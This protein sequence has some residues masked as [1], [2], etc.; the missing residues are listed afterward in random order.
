SH[1]ITRMTSHKLNDIIHCTPRPKGQASRDR[2]SKQGG[3]QTTLTALQ[4]EPVEQRILHHRP[5]AHHRLA[6][7]LTQED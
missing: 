7:R 1:A 3:S 4:A 5:L 6:S 2:R